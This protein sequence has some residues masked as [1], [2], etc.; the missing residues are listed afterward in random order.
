MKTVLLRVAV[1]A[2]ASAL[3]AGMAV[4]QSENMG[5]ITVE[6]TRSVTTK[7]VGKTSS[8]IPIKDVSLSYGVLLK[9]LDL[10]SHAGF[11]EAERRVKE[12]AEAACKELVTRYPSG[13]PS[14]AAC[15]KAAADK[16][17]VVVNGWAALAGK[18]SGQ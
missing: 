9:G 1:G 11:V 7:L 17:M 13:T 12:V 8:G 6:G 10:A 3:V 16:A 18:A 15:A 14:E 4:A 5:E 2:V